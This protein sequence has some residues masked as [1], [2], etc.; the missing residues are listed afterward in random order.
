MG[1][2]AVKWCGYTV[3]VQRVSL[4]YKVKKFLDNMSVRKIKHGSLWS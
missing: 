2:K 3:Y 4:L 1:W